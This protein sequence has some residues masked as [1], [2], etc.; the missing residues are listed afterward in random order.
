MDIELV[1]DHNERR[2]T[3]ED[4]VV[5]GGAVPYGKQLGEIK[6]KQRKATRETQ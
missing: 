6:G 4:T 5:P 1:T 3:S 2:G